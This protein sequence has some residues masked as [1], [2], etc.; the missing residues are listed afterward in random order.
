[1]RP[2]ENLSRKQRQATPPA[3]A[4]YLLRKVRLQFQVHWVGCL[5]IAEKSVYHGLPGCD[6]WPLSRDAFAYD[7]IG[8][9]IAHPP[10][11]SWGKYRHNCSHGLEHGIKAMELVEQFGGVVEQPLGSRLFRE[12]GRWFGQTIEY[13]EQGMYGHL[14]KKPTLL[15]WNFNPKYR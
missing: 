9:I 1:M 13:V 8:P 7:G 4:E 2:L 12:Y 14:A 11:G 10:C 15:Y 5:W 6:C 3:F